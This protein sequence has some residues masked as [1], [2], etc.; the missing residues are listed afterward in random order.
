[1]PFRATGYC[2]EAANFA[3]F[4]VGVWKLTR[5]ECYDIVLTTTSRQMTGLLGALVASRSGARLY[6]DLRD[7]F[8]QNLEAMLPWPLRPLAWPTRQAERWALRRADRIS[9]TSEAF[10]PYLQGE[11][12]T[13]KARYFPNGTDELF[14]VETA[15]SSRAEGPIEILYAGNIGAGQELHSIVPQLA[16][17]LGKNARFRIIGDGH[18]VS[19]LRSAIKAA[20]LENVTLET[21]VDRAQL[22]LLYARADVLFLHLGRAASLEGVSTFKDF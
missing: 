20:R 2:M 11:G 18:Q 3:T 7:L 12:H 5:N 17:R 8:A 16:S 13:D 21:P 15:P 22:A 14:E 19:L 10:L 9:I 1:M 4:A 6:L